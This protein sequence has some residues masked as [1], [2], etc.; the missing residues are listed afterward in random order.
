MRLLYIIVFLFLGSAIY[1]QQDTVRIK[2]LWNEN[3]TAKLRKKL[4]AF[5][6][7]ASVNIDTLRKPL[8]AATDSAKS[9]ITV[10]SYKQ[11][12]GILSD[13]TQIIYKQQKQKVD[14]LQSSLASKF[15]S[16][17]TAPQKLLNK[18][19]Q[20]IDRLRTNLD[21]RVNALESKV[22]APADSIRHALNDKMNNISTRAGST[23]A[24]VKS[25]I[26]GGDLKLPGADNNLPAIGTPGKEM[27]ALN[28]NLK[29]ETPK[30]NA[31]DEFNKKT[32]EISQW[33][34]QKLKELPG[35]EQYTK[36]NSEVSQADSKLQQFHTIEKDVK[37][38]REGKL[39][40]VKQLPEE[41]EKQIFNQTDA[42]RVTKEME[43]A[44]AI[45]EQYEGML[46]RYQDKK[47]IQQELQ[48]RS[49]S[50]ANDF[51]NQNLPIVKQSQASMAK[52][53]RVYGNFQSLK[54]LPKKRPNEMK[55][56]P[57]SIRLVPS[58][59]FQIY[60][61]DILVVDL[62]PQIGYR[63]TS[64]LI[65]GI[66][67][68]YRINMNSKYSYYLNQSGVC[69]GYVFAEWTAWKGMFAHVDFY[70]LHVNAEAYSK[71]QQATEDQLVSGGHVGIGKSYPVSRR[72]KGSV[73][74]LYRFEFE[75]EM[76][77]Q[78]KFGLRV[79]FSWKLKRD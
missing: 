55:G 75:G 27:P 43:K 28:L 53:K 31:L 42:Q 39:S 1:A 44:K 73:L 10:D 62:M 71:A 24:P 79:G 69:G 72:L 60:Q 2:K 37:N 32:T 16:V 3:Q 76:P 26:P 17:Q 54:N 46:Q 70:T 66:G 35:V 67:G 74:G 4:A 21:Q 56:K 57:L 52:A 45:R 34:D 6:S 23:V 49:K 59:Q 63:F 22:K 38:L 15:N 18:V 50:L 61:A 33:P 30:L 7:K 41:L 25:I 12:I 5:R 68:Q 36:I 48:A 20:P 58:L 65:G 13:T 40:E 64:R 29:S 47:R 51:V 78:D 9:F 19:T 77:R 8:I 11:K 14:S